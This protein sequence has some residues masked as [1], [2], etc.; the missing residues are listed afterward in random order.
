[1]KSRLFCVL[2]T[3]LLT[4]AFAAPARLSTVKLKLRAVLVD[5]QLNQKPVPFIVVTMQGPGDSTGITELKTGLDGAVDKELL[6]GKYQLAVAKPLDFDG[7]RY[8][9]KMEVTLAGAEQ[10]II[11]SNDNAKVEAAP[12][13]TA[14]PTPVGNELSDQFKRLKN[15]A[16][17][18]LS[19]SGHGTG[20]FVDDQ[21]L[22]LTNQHVIAN[23]EYL[24][25]QFDSEHKII[26]ELVAS[27]SQKDVA[28]LR[29]NMGAFPGAISAP[30]AK[31][32]DGKT[33]VQE[34]ERVFTIGSPL[35]LDKILT[36]GVVS[37]VEAHTL[38]SDVNINP[39]NSGG[40]LFNSAGLVIGL[41][42][43]GEHSGTGPGVSGVVRI[44]DALP[45]LEA[46]RSKASGIPPSAALLPVAPIK[47]Y[48]FDGLKAALLPEKYDW[49]PY[50]MSV[51]EYFVELSTPPM[52]YRAQ[53][54]KRLTAEKAR[55][56]RRKKQGQESD[57]TSTEE[58]P[59]NWESEAG[60]HKAVIGIYIMP[61]AKEG[62]WSGMGRAASGGIT[63]MNV[64]FKTDFYR[65]RLMCGEKEVAPIHP[66]K[67][68]ASF[69]LR[70]ARLNFT[71]A[72]AFGDY[73]YPPD[74]FSPNCGQERLEIYP[75][76]NSV[77][78]VVKIL[79]PGTIERVW[80]DFEAFRKAATAPLSEKPETAPKPSQKP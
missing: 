31:H 41:T 32:Q 70:N 4:G 22:I 6:A 13:A 64:K 55:A 66:G 75:S 67:I 46:N 30:L 79:E 27:D 50:S 33:A 51:G 40:P 38:L 20:F 45:I 57:S 14:T 77:E 1:M 29:A 34:G 53:E 3:L 9:W 73:T 36:T 42:T 11:L 59:K 68:P 19:E 60:G 52:E 80:T 56:K 71:D 23:S 44:E 48:P 10:T 15:S 37:K 24:A 17:T 65:M 26:A 47:P 54:E 76:K 5:S 2:L 49:K 25:V 18:V 74:A 21:G 28:L 8:T 58:A 12:A 62:F 16:V 63:P 69:A 35:T 39:G 72:A 43:F 78:P 7:K 61:K